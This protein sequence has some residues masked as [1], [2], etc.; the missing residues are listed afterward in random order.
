MIRFH[1]QNPAIMYAGAVSG[2]IFKSTDSGQNWRPMTDELPNLAV[3]CFE[4]DA[5]NPNTLYLGTGEGYYNADAVL[6]IGL[7]KSTDGGADVEHHGAELQLRRR[8][9]DHAHQHRSAQQQDRAGRHDARALPLD[10]RRHDFHARCSTATS[11]RWCATRSTRTRCWPRRATRGA[12]TQN[13]IYRST[14]NGLTWTRLHGRAAA[15]SLGRIVLAFAPCNP[16]IVYAGVCGTFSDNGTQMLGIYKSTDNG[17]TWTQVSPAGTSH[18]ASQ[19]L[20][21]HGAGGEARRPGAGALRRASTSTA[22]TNSG[23]SWTQ[24]SYWYYTF[25]NPDY[26]HADHHEIVFHPTN[27]TE[28]W[29]ATDGGIFRSTDLG[30]T[31]TEMN[32]GFVT[33]QYYAMG[34]ATLDTL[35]SYGGTQDNGTFGYHGSRTSPS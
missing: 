26:V 2:G 23:A 17:Q 1:P 5:L 30:N 13:G 12:A 32:N 16:Q 18:Y 21:R 24:L 25:G 8:A 29:E 7:L 3:G 34:N 15:D 14:N 22:R 27:T 9:G 20:V 28:V 35:L 31:W 4:I 33:F 6:G 11:R 10:Q 19:A